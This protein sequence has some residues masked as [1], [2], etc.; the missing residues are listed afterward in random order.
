MPEIKIEQVKKLEKGDYLLVITPHII[1]DIKGF[2]VLCQ[3]LVERGIYL[4]W[5]FVQ[6]ISAVKL[7]SGEKLTPKE[8]VLK[9]A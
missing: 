6:D 2:E 1:I 8:N 4:H 3:G 7:I 5:L 9:D